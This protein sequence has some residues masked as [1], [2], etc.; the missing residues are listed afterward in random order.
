MRQPKLIML[1]FAL[2]MS[3]TFLVGCNSVDGIKQT[4]TFQVHTSYLTRVPSSTSTPTVTILPTI[5]AT[6]M[7][8]TPTYTVGPSLTPTWTATWTPVPTLSE[9]VRKQNLIKWFTTN[10]GCKYP[11]FWGVNPGAPFQ[12][13][14]S[15]S[16]YIGEPP[17]KYKNEYSFLISLDELNFLDFSIDYYE[18]K[19]YV[20][21]IRARLTEAVRHPDYMDAFGISFSL[22]SILIHYGQPSNVLLQIQPRVEINSPIGYTLYLLYLRE[23]FAVEYAGVVSSEDPLIVC[24]FLEDYHLRSIGLEIQD[25]KAMESLQGELLKQGFLPIE[26][27]TSMSRDDFYETFSSFENNQCIE[28]SIDYWK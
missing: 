13:V 19:G 17:I 25:S 20:E 24:V 15:L 12:Q 6:G 21:K 27:V 11:C 28:T 5:T 14:F 23:G 3:I 22:S 1:L 16:P 18:K 2:Y 26:E 10:G 8:E 7:P 4:E 9:E